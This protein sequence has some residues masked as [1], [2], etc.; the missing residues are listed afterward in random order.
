MRRT[1]IIV[2]VTVILG[3]VGVAGS[4]SGAPAALPVLPEGYENFV[5][6]IDYASFI[7]DVVTGSSDMDC[8]VQ[9][10]N[11]AN[12]PVGSPFN[13][14]AIESDPFG[15]GLKF[16]QAVNGVGNEVTASCHVAVSIPRGTRSTKGPVTNEALAPLVGTTSG[17]FSL[18]C[19]LESSI[20]ATARVQFGGGVPGKFDVVVTGADKAI[21]FNCALNVAFGSSSLNGSVRGSAEIV[22][23]ESVGLCD[24]L[25]TISCVPLRLSDA[26]VRITSSTG[27]FGGL[28]GTGTY[29]FAES[30]GLKFI[31]DKMKSNQFVS[32][33]A[34][35]VRRASVRTMQL[36]GESLRVNLTN[37]KRST[38]A[39]LR[40]LGSGISLNEG[41]AVAGTAKAACTLS[42][43]VGA[44]STRIASFTL[45]TSGRASA[46]SFSSKV[47]KAI[48]AKKGSTVTLT[49]SCKGTDKKTTV[50]TKRVKYLG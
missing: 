49:A 23:P 44:K 21:P 15:V 12:F 17:Q 29:S 3:S 1:S 4:A 33:T 50:A 48:G 37:S 31:D 18:D 16:L 35:S 43:K 27:K 39:L 42:A 24:G 10:S 14:A 5:P 30:F 19:D 46:R 32:I 47:V 22:E 20:V 40:P 13:P 26:T 9:S 41:I 8:A 6:N 34:S 38:T 36:D 25:A 11:V 45:G 7:G 28:T 2:L